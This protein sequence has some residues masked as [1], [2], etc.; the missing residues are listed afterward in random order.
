MSL[1][2]AFGCINTQ[3]DTQ[4][5]WIGLLWSRWW[6]GGHAGADARG[7]HCWLGRWWVTFQ[8]GCTITITGF[9]FAV[10]V[11]EGWSAAAAGWTTNERPATCMRYLY[12]VLFTYKKAVH[13]RVNMRTKT[14]L[15]AAV[16]SSSYP[17]T[18]ISIYKFQ[19]RWIFV[20]VCM[21]SR[22]FFLQFKNVILKSKCMKQ[23]LEKFWI[24]KKN[25]LNVNRYVTNLNLKKNWTVFGNFDCL[26]LFFKILKYW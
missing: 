23:L 5:R 4:Q 21:C 12:P 24:T 20:W 9:T 14:C 22:V 17:Y 13:T 6:Y 16:Q 2:I 25:C 8:N 19:L 7:L 26:R 3:E 18:A 10:L 11:K 15:C 1:Y